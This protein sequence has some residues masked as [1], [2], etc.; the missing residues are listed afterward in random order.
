MMKK[1]ALPVLLLLVCF[2]LSWAEEFRATITKVDGGK[3]TFFKNKGKGEKGE[4]GTLPVADKVK[5]LKTKF[6][7]ET[8]KAEA[9]DPI[10]D[11]LKN[12]MFTKIGER[13]LRATIVTDDK[14]EKITEIRAGG[15]FRGKDKN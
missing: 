2:G 6:N 14:G 5:V 11:G 15:G 1:F 3:V 12:E 10:E 8:M 9:G 7:K 4:E 13:G